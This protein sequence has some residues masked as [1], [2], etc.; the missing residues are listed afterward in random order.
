MRKVSRRLTSAPTATATSLLM[1]KAVSTLAGS[2]LEPPRVVLICLPSIV[3]NLE[4]CQYRHQQESAEQRWAGCLQRRFSATENN[5]EPIQAN[6][7]C[8]ID[9][10]RVKAGGTDPMLLYKQSGDIWAQGFLEFA[11]TTMPGPGGLD[12]IRVCPGTSDSF[13]HRETNS[14]RNLE[15]ILPCTL[16][17]GIRYPV[18][19]INYGETFRQAPGGEHAGCLTSLPYHNKLGFTISVSDTRSAIDRLSR[20]RPLATVVCSPSPSPEMAQRP[21]PEAQCHNRTDPCDTNFNPVN[22]YVQKHIKANLKTLLDEIQLDHNDI[23]CIPSLFKLSDCG[24]GGGFCHG[25]YWHS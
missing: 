25:T 10:A 24:S 23:I 22:E 11:Y 1:S 8:Q 19:R 12:A 20:P 4:D 17:S 6:S 2:P 9:E 7:T 3:N 13:G 18:E 5:S 16:K 21:G 15:A 14:F